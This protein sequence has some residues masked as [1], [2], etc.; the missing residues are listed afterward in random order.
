MVLKGLKM[1][2][3]VRVV[4]HMGDGRTVNVTTE[5]GK[6]VLEVAREAIRGIELDDCIV[7][8]GQQRVAPTTIINEDTVISITPRKPEGGAGKKGKKNVKKAGKK[9]VKK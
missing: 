4:S 2:I 9:S 3:E 7:R 1:S 8:M 5:S 6:S